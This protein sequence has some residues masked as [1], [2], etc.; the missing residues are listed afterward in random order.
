MKN[1]TYI[2]DEKLLVSGGKRFLNYILDLSFYVIFIV[3]LAFITAVIATLLGLTNVLLWMQNISDLQS[4]I[5]AVIV[6]IIYYVLTEGILGRSLAKFITG[7]IV[8]DENGEKPSFGI[9]FQRTL[10]RLI[11]F[12]AFSFL[13]NS[14]RGWHDSISDTYVVDKKE[15]EKSLR[16]FNEMDQIGEVS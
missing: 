8:V 1:T 13:G 10:C 14:G 4:N 16:I 7:T 12:E 9:F 3:F 15:L 5:I 6:M 11:P 2:L